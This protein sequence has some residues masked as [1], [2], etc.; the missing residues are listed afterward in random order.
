MNVIYSDK[1]RQSTEVYPLLHQATQYLEQALGK[2]AGQAKVEWDRQENGDGQTRYDLRLSHGQESV[3]SSL[4]QEEL[5]S[6][7]DMEFRLLD[8]WGDLLEQRQE[9]QLQ[10]LQEAAG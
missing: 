3:S 8:L 7:F 10:E 1:A 2:S 6:Q 4:T 5:Q 9:R